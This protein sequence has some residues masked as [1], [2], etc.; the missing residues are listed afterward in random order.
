MPETTPRNFH[1][2]MPEALYER[3]RKEAEQSGEPATEIAGRAIT[4][5][6]DGYSTILDHVGGV[7]L[8][9]G[10]EDRLVLSGIFFGRNHRGG[11]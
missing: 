6:P 4:G 1:V 10:S 9:V 8:G 2:P 3:L 7:R 5:A 11:D